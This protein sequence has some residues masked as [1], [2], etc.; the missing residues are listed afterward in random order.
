MIIAEEKWEDTEKIFK[1]MGF[2]R[3]YPPRVRIPQIIADL[4][5]DIQSRTL[6]DRHGAQK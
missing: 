5:T 2:N 1:E 4:E 6:R 3:V